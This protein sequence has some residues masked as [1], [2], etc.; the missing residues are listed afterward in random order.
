MI[1]GSNF[2]FQLLTVA[3]AFMSIASVAFA[4]TR[5]SVKPAV[6]VEGT[7]AEIALSDIVVA[8]GL[9]RTAIE[10]F[11]AIRLSD[12]PKPGEVRSFTRSTLEAAIQP[13]LDAVS[14]ATGEK[15]ELKLPSRVTITKKKFRL[16]K[17][18][19]QAE[20]VNQFKS[21][22][23]DC[24]IQISNLSL[25]MIGTNF[26]PETQWS[27]RS[28]PDL[29][30]GSF[31]IPIEIVQSSKPAQTYWISGQ[32]SIRKPVSV[33]AREIAIGERVQSQDLIV[34]MKDV[35]F[36]T[37]VPVSEADLTAG[38]AARQIAAGQI[39][40]RSSIRKELA[41]R[42]GDS[43]KVSAGSANWQITLEG[44]SQT[45]GYV[46]DTVRVKI[47]STQKLVSGLLK[48]KGVVEVQ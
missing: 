43:V 26:A 8:N 48:E 31:S 9:S 13:E 11:R 16:G 22:C 27:I 1:K 40:F 3:M 18:E 28:R 17:D 25:P 38:V 33:A 15:F 6:E 21:Q 29:P 12:A 37:D 41:V 4:D 5:V 30:K 2:S 46:G 14:A 32:V 42:N 34:Q 39:V 19:I 45:S 10:K 47:P 44:I 35:T 24:E 23:A 7:Q 36:A 20:L